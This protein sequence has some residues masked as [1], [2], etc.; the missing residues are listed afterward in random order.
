MVQ[1]CFNEVANCIQYELNTYSYCITCKTPMAPDAYGW[2]CVTEFTAIPRCLAHNRS[3]PTKCAICQDGFE[4]PDCKGLDYCY[5]A[6]KDINGKALNSCNV[7]I[8][9]YI[10][11]VDGKCVLQRVD[12]CD[13]AYDSFLCAKCKDGYNLIVNPS[14]EVSSWYSFC[15][16]VET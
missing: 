15:D 8:T 6:N 9:G 12:N 3:D 10:R 5:Q 11:T 7:C 2:A 1:T 13:V 4:A 16:Q 14:H